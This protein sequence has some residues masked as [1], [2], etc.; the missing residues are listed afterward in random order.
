MCGYGITLNLSPAGGK[1]KYVRVH[2]MP[3]KFYKL[4]KKGVKIYVHHKKV[5][6]FREVMEY[7]SECALEWHAPIKFCEKC[8][9]KG[10]E[11]SITF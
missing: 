11:I 1:S 4:H 7:V 8:F 9:K 6:T 3:C 2:K 5:K 10:E